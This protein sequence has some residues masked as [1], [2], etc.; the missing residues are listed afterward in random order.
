MGRSR[1]LVGF[2]MDHAVE[3]QQAL[4]PQP[5]EVRE[6]NRSTFR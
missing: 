5:S 2:N 6:Q 1:S 3:Y 4:D